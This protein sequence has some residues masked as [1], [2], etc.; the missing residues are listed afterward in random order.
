LYYTF[1]KMLC[2][3][4]LILT[5]IIGIPGTILIGTSLV[6]KDISFTKVINYT[7]QISIGKF[8]DL[9]L[10]T[11]ITYLTYAKIVMYLNTAGVGFLLLFSIFLRRKLKL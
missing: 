7:T 3:V 4:L 1:K 10:N 8:F 9:N 2:I 6:G 11:N 5:L